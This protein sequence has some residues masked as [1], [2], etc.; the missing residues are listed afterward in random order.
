MHNVDE[1]D[2]TI[3]SQGGRWF[4]VIEV[5]ITMRDFFHSPSN[6]HDSVAS[7]KN[8]RLAVRNRLLVFYT[9]FRLMNVSWIQQISCNQTAH[10]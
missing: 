5:G 2:V 10:L 3:A 6:L 7:V 8:K 1:D 9:Y 4:N